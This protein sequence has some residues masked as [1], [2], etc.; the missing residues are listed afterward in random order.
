MLIEP[1]DDRRDQRRAL[2]AAR[3]EAGRARA[4]AG[5]ARA[6]AMQARADAARA[7]AAAEKAQADARRVSRSPLY[8]VGHVVGRVV[9]EPTV[10]ARVPGRVA[11]AVRRRIRP[12]SGGGA[13]GG[14]AVVLVPEVLPIPPT[15][16]Q[17]RGGDRFFLADSGVA[18]G[19][20]TRAVVLGILT[21][22]T[23]DALSETATVDRVTPNDALLVL[24]RTE[25]DLVLVETAAFA[26]TMPWAY[27][28][29]P[30]AVER[31]SVLAQL[32]D[33]ARGLGRP[34]VLI[35]GGR[36]TDAVGLIPLEPRFDIIRD[37]RPDEAGGIG[38]SRG[39]A[40]TRF[41]PI[42]RTADPSEVALFV[43][44][45][46]A[47]PDPRRRDLL[48]A[49]LQAVRDGGLEIVL[50][51]DGPGG[52][53]DLPAEVRDRVI[54]RIGRDGLAPRYRAAS[55]A[56]TDPFGAPDRG[57]M[58]DPRAL[59]QLACGLRLVSGPDRV[60]LELAGMH[61]H[62]AESVETAGDAIAAARSAGRPS[63]ADLRALLRRLFLQAA[64]P[65]MLGRLTHRLG[66]SIDPLAG[67]SVT[68][69]IAV[70]E[71][72]DVDRLVDSIVGQR[73]RPQR[74]VVRT[75]DPGPW[76]GAAGEAIRAAG[77][78]VEVED[79][80][81]AER[82]ARTRW[83]VDWP[84]DR[85]LA[86]DVLLDLLVGGE[87]S[88]AD[89]VTL[90]DGDPFRFT[91]SF[92]DGPILL[93]ARA[94][95]AAAVSDPFVDGRWRVLDPATTGWRVLS[96]GPE[97]LVVTDGH[98]D[99]ST[100]GRP[101]R[102]ALVY[103]DVDLNLIDGSAIWATSVVE[104][105]ARAGCEV[106]LL[107]K[108]RVRTDRLIAPLEAL[109]GVHIVRPFEDGRVRGSAE[110]LDRRRAAA[111]MADLDAEERFD[112]VVVRGF[113]LI[114]AVVAGARFDGRTVVVPDRRPAVGRRDHPAGHRPAVG[115]RPGLALRA[116]P[117]RGAALV[118]RDDGARDGRALRPVPAG[119]APGRAG[120]RPRPSIR[121]ARCGSATP[122]SS[123]RSGTPRP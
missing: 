77:M 98:V 76:S 9:H 32:V 2:E 24:E 4:D 83:V 89:A 114:G 71:H 91:T 79:R 81:D 53:E 18:I 123:R 84:T 10:L 50:D 72:T 118:P 15:L 54:G 93:D 11:R 66:V 95:A 29:D 104:V 101:A 74:V 73:A 45:G 38:W 6:E 20:R 42:G 47:S 120:R 13:A 109:P 62:V 102:R 103:G 88:G 63:A 23:A 43:T 44:G 41:H 113:G 70:D 52:A 16:E 25:P 121:T 61:V 108:A 59:E 22:A 27:A 110:K 57:R 106:T 67:R 1:D 49:T 55:L 64:S 99:G 105:L 60:L 92:G 39:V 58:V 122:A 7:Q 94:L 69:L 119:P 80:H 33:R 111:V 75:T 34:S 48:L 5:L 26:P 90:G 97:A 107:L 12:S 85:P 31:A 115:D 87:M 100:G 35:R 56:V 68:A 46:R 28:G 30:A 117:D 86:P 14:T 19:A 37:Q 116:V 65:V 17:V 112:V 82:I 51:G 96:I 40:L 36:A 78:P 8:R 21:D 3:A